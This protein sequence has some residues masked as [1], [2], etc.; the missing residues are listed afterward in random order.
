M[1]KF[2]LWKKLPKMWATCAIFKKKLPKVSNRPMGENSPNLVTLAL[3]PDSLSAA[4]F[5]VLAKLETNFAKHAHP[6]QL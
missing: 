6:L 5:F 1:S 2:L 3:S 4:Q